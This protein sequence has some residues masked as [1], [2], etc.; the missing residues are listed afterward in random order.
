MVGVG[1][2]MKIKTKEKTDVLTQKNVS[3]ILNVN[4]SKNSR[5]G[6]RKEVDQQVCS[7]NIAREFSLYNIPTA[8]LMKNSLY[9]L[10]KKKNYVENN[11]LLHYYEPAKFLSFRSLMVYQLSWVIQC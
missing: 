10:I 1:K 6:L 7:P 11:N 8:E 3:V 9:A 5:E 2:E 4:Y